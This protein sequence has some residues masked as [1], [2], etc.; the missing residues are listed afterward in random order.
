MPLTGRQEDPIRSLIPAVVV[1][2]RQIIRYIQLHG[3][4]RVTG[5]T[6]SALQATRASTSI[7]IAAPSQLDTVIRAIIHTIVA[8]NFIVHISV[9]YTLLSSSDDRC[10]DGI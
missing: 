2:V 8:G 10:Y 4:P 3:V 7:A 1:K 9:F 5:I 6:V